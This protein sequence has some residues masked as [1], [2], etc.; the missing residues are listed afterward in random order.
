MSGLDDFR[1]LANLLAAFL[2]KNNIELGDKKD[3][4]FELF[5]EYQK[6]NSL[7]GV[8]GLRQL[9]HKEKNH[10]D[11]NVRLECNGVH[12]LEC[13]LEIANP[14]I[15]DQN[16]TCCEHGKPIP[17]KIRGRILAEHKRVEALFRLCLL[18]NKR[19]DKMNFAILGT[20]P[21]CII[22]TQCIR[23]KYDA[24]KKNNNCPNCNQAYEDESEIT[25]RCIV[26]ADMKE[27]DLFQI[28][29]SICV[30]CTKEKDSREFLQV[31]SNQCKVCSNCYKGL[32]DNNNK[33]CLAKDCG[34]LV[35]VVRP[36]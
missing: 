6:T 2:I 9:I 36:D 24:N 19:L 30:Q 29:K 31:C 23:Q 22:C 5:K 8:S 7:I 34:A 28:Y 16:N 3:Q 26:E 17:P 25:I 27:E 14:P 15:Y 4:L 35:S 12:C 33:T 32:L 13:Y 18:C 21:Q 20:H 10:A 1:T 11:T